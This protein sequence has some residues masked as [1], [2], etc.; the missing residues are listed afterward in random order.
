VIIDQNILANREFE[1]STVRL[2]RLTANSFL[3]NID[4]VIRTLGEFG[5]EAEQ[6]QKS[7]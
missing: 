1:T 6:L 2:A 7:R 3:E 4:L 5:E